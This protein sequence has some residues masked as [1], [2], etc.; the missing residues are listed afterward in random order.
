MSVGLFKLLKKYDVDPGL[1]L[2]PLACANETN[3]WCRR[4]T[5]MVFIQF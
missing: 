2:L 4:R 5:R 3:V 1:G